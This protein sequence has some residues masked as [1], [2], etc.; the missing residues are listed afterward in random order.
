MMCKNPEV[1]VIVVN[2]NGKHHLQGCLD[3]LRSQSFRDF[4][5]IL[6]DNGSEDGSVDFV[7]EHYPEVILVENKENRGF[8]GGNNDGI[9]VS[10][11]KY[12]FL[13]NNDT[14]LDKECLNALYSA[15]KSSPDTCFGIFPKVLFA[16]APTFINS[17]GVVWNY[18][19]LW[20]D[21]RIGLIDMDQFARPERIFGSMFVALLVKRALFED[22]GFFDEY[23]FTYGEDFD[24]CYRAGCRGYFFLTE[25]RAVVY[26]KFRA[27][28]QETRDPLWSFYL[29]FRNYYY[30]VL[31]NLSW[32]E[33]WAAK[34]F[35]VMLYLY[36]LYWGYL[37]REKRRYWL[38]VK[39]PLALL[40]RSRIIWQKRKEVSA[41]RRV[42]DFA[43]WD[44]QDRLFHS[45]FCYCNRPV[46]NAKNLISALAMEGTTEAQD[47]S[48]FPICSDQWP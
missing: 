7:L 11:G 18:R 4:E 17:Y 14:V 31:K 5:I 10:K 42:K 2:Y 36:N 39:M 15:V 6:V 27:S 1:S 40:K 13:L 32:K 29:F 16:D 9:A 33:L 44:F 38:A 20:N 34:K 21:H 24:V 43:F 19:C 8:C 26:H 47:T 3:S 28:S 48:I 41:K 30:L 45:P 25:P 12:L 35:L 23:M 37:N 22:I 46:L